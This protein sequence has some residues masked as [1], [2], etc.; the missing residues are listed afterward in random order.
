MFARCSVRMARI[1][2]SSWFVNLATY[3][4]A[5]RCLLAG[6]A[7]TRAAAVLLDE[8]EAGRFQVRRSGTAFER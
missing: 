3:L 7:D 8:L 4:A 5:D 2:G 6:L 1:G